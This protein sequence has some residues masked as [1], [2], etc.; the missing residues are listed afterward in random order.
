MGRSGLEVRIDGV[1]P[2]DVA[3]FAFDLEVVL[4]LPGIRD[5]ERG[6]PGGV[7][8]TDQRRKNGAADLVRIV[9]FDELHA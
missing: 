4:L 5:D 7:P 6:L 2:L 9:H 1:D 8:L 3:G